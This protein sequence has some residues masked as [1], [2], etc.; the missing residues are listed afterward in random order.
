MSAKVQKR[1]NKSLYNCCIYEVNEVTNLTFESNDK[2]RLSAL[3]YLC[4]LNSTN[5]FA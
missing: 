1:I 5:T 2:C 3:L 4:P